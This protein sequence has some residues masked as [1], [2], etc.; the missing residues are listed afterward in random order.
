MGS[1]ESTWS[2]TG[3]HVVGGIPEYIKYCQQ[4]S[5]TFLGLCQHAFLPDGFFTKEYQRIFVSSLASNKH[6][7]EIIEYLAKKSFASRK[8]ILTHL[9]IQSSGSLTEVMEDLELCGF[10]ERYTPYHLK[11]GSLLTRYRIADNYLRFYYKFIKPI[12]AD[13]Q[14]GRYQDN[15]SQAINLDT[16]N[17]WLGYAF[18]RFCCQQH[19]SIAKILGFHG[20]K[21]TAG[22]FFNHA[23][24]KAIPNYQCDLVFDRS[25]K[26]I[27]ICEVKYLQTVVTSR[28]IEEF[29]RKLE[30]FPNKQRKTLQKVLIT[31]SDVSEEVKKRHYF[32]RIIR[33]GDLFDA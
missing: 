10:V 26:V 14:S 5:S 7:R 22:S 21:Y 31:A 16:Y 28:V 11:P 4:G 17:K 20:I 8:E 32:D 19:H 9:K 24:E 13:I 3:S 15:P 2:T 33:L 1:P 6:Y 30:Y 25:D 29:E 23:G 27:T 12:D 18:E